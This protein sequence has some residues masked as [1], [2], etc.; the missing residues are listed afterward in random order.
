MAFHKK[1]PRPVPSLAFQSQP[2]F[3]DFF[4]MSTNVFLNVSSCFFTS[5][6]DLVTFFYRPECSCHLP[7]HWAL[8]TE[9]PPS[10]FG[11][12]NSSSF[13]SGC[14]AAACLASR[15]NR[16]N[17]QFPGLNSFCFQYLKSYS[18]FPGWILIQVISQLLLQWVF[19]VYILKS[20]HRFFNSS[21]PQWLMSP[22]TY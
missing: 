8:T 11:T 6:H 10:S 21:A 7:G 9:I 4:S 20:R 12:R 18:H 14:L 13:S 2:F 1:Y 15:L 17:N 3:S 16:Q 19:D 22:F 5:R